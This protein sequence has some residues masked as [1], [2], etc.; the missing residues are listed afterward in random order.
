MLTYQVPYPSYSLPPDAGLDPMLA[1]AFLV[2]MTLA[3]LWAVLDADDDVA[4]ED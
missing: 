1:S 4:H 3:A 2:V